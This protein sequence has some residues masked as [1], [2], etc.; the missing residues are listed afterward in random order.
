MI[1]KSMTRICEDCGK[2]KIYP[3]DFPKW[4]IYRGRVVYRMRCKECHI[5]R[6]R[7][8]P[9]YYD[10]ERFKRYRLRNLHKAKAQGCLRDAVRNG[11]VEKPNKCFLCE[12]EFDKK[13]IH[14]HHL[15]YSKPLKVVWVCRICHKKVHTILPVQ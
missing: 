4:G 7:E 15:D 5:I 6:R 2:E 10:N 3:D 13:Y 14:G 1:Q 8:Q 9:S 12:N 11:F